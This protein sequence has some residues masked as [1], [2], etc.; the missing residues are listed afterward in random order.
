[1]RLAA[2]TPGFLRMTSRGLLASA[3]AILAWFAMSAWCHA[4]WADPIEY[5]PGTSPFR[6]LLAD[7]RETHHSVR[8]LVGAGR[9]RG[10]A[11]FG[12]TFGLARVSNSPVA[13]VGLQASV[14]T[15]FNRDADSAGFLD[16]NSADYMIFIPV[17]VQLG[18]VTVRSGI[19]HI[20][21]HLGEMEVQHQILDQGASFFDR[22]F[23][24][25]RDY[26][27]VVAAWD[28]TERLRVYGGASVAVH[29]TPDHARTAAQAG[30]EWL[31]PPRPFGPILRQWFGGVDLQ[32]WAESDWAANGN[33]EAGVRLSRPDGERAIRFAVSGYAGRSLQR[34]LAAQREH[35]LSAGL[36]FEF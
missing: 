33:L 17:D 27:R 29:I 9:A 28:A 6:P 16:I 4:A 7:P 11:S 26:V 14:F 18:A 8:Y 35:Y 3:G 22:R 19:G 13:Q 30:V 21:S 32:T 15:R 2:G 36:V 34:I 25:R 1:V 31:G 10:E 5:F 23:L 24:Y 12:D 20:S